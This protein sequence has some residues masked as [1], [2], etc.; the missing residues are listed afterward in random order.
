MA[1]IRHSRQRDS[2]L[3]ELFSRKDHPTADELYASL[4]EQI[5]NIS[6]ATVYRNLSLLYDDG[7]ILRLKCGDTA[8]RFDGNI[9]PHYH[10]YCNQCRRLYDVD[11]PE[12]DL[13]NNLA[14]LEYKGVIES[15]S[16]TFYGICEKCY[17]N[18]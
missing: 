10:L 2:I 18:N 5:P 4:R 7:I 6:L 12:I 11:I 15:H 8:D 3:N 14:K 9:A 16:I 1:G 17:S 13:I